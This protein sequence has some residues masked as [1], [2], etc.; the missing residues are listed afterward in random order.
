MDYVTTDN[1]ESQS[2]AQGPDSMVLLISG[3]HPLN[4]CYNLALSLLG[5]RKSN[6]SV[7]KFAQ[8]KELRCA[9]EDSED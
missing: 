5:E 1:H 6:C 8:R 9:T 2:S 7:R 4:A 3:S